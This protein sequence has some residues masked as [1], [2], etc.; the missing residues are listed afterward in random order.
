MEWISVKER[1]PCQREY[2]W[3]Y[4]NTCQESS[5]YYVFDG[6][7][8]LNSFDFRGP[9]LTTAPGWEYDT[10]HSSFAMIDQVSHWTPYF[11]P[12]P[13]TEGQ[14]FIPCY[15]EPDNEE[16]DD[17]QISCKQRAAEIVEII[18]RVSHPT[19][20]YPDLLRDTM[21]LIEHLYTGDCDERKN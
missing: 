8:D 18:K 1:L 16:L 12:E 5:G 6:Y 7:F 14:E 13:P 19:D 9:K 21:K 11:T 3:L 10:E 17:A 20:R 4:G 2:C 15:C